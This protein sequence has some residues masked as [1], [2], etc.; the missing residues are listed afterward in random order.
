VSEVRFVASD[1]ARCVGCGSCVAACA[2][3]KEGRY[4]PLR[5]RIVLAADGARP[6]ATACR[7]CENAPCRFACPQKALAQDKQTRLIIINPEKCQTVGWCAHECP[8]G[9]ISVRPDGKAVVCDLCG[10]EPACIPYCPTGALQ[11]VT[12]EQFEKWS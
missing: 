4:N 9:A 1:P 11:M 7:L 12:A 8:Y 6:R 2:A 3:V 5:S 10:G